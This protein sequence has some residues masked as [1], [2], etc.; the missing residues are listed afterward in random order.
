MKNDIAVFEE[1]KIRRVYN[2]DTETWFFSVVDIIRVLTNSPEPGA[3]WR[4]L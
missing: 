4:K 1:A 3:Y 2:E